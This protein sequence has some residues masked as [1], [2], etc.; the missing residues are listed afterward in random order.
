MRMS[1]LTVKRAEFPVKVDRSL[2]MKMYAK[3]L[4]DKFKGKKK[5]GMLVT[6]PSTY[7]GSSKY[8]RELVM[9]AITISNELGNPHLFITFTGN[10]KWPEIVRACQAR[11]C[12]WADIPE[13]VNRVFKRRYELFLDDILGKKKKDRKKNGKYFRESGIFGP[14]VWYNYSVEFQ[15]RGMPHCHLLVCLKNP[16]TNAAQVDEI[17]TAEVP[18]LPDE[19]DPDKEKVIV[20]LFR[21]ILIYISTEI[22]LLHIGQGSYGA[23]PLRRRRFSIL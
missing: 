9:K 14:V 22:R 8:Q 3:M 4:D 23:H 10:P 11:Q 7:P 12:E 15:Q 17:I 16:I 6:M 1:A 2:L 18:D 20:C 5:L 13:I 19:S 21:S